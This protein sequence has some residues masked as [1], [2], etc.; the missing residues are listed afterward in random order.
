MA[1]FFYHLHAFGGNG[2]MKGIGQKT[3]EAI[4]GFTCWINTIGL[5]SK[6]GVSP[7][8]VESLEVVS[9]ECWNDG[10]LEE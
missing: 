4:Q 6:L 8:P 3:V 1:H 10:I 9:L 5:N 7:Q 2:K